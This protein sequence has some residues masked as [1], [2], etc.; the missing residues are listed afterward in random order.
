MEKVNFKFGDY[1]WF[2]NEGWI[3]EGIN[4][5]GE[6][7]LV[8]PIRNHPFHIVEHE[9]VSS[10]NEINNFYE[11]NGIR[12]NKEK[13][14]KCKNKKADKKIAGVDFGINDLYALFENLHINLETGK[15]TN[16]TNN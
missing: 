10:I 15:V 1:V 5:D 6:Y 7:C 2:N 13:F 14:C 3:Y 8:R 9:T 12:K 4:E 16:E 11:E